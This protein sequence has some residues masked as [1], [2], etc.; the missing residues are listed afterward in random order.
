MAAHQRTLVEEVADMKITLEASCAAKTELE[1]VVEQGVLQAERDAA[2]AEA[3]AAWAEAE[4]MRAEEGLS[5]RH[6]AEVAA[7]EK[8]PAFSEFHCLLLPTLAFFVDPACVVLSCL[9]SWT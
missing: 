3:R 2:R 9:E 4:G 1:R 5:Q 8:V 6:V 7:A